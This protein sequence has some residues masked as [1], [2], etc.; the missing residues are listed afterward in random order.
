MGN[1]SGLKIKKLEVSNLLGNKQVSTSARFEGQRYALLIV[2]AC[3]NFYAKRVCSSWNDV[4]LILTKYNLERRERWLIASRKSYASD[5]LNQSV[6]MIGFLSNL[7]LDLS[8]LVIL[9]VY[10]K[11]ITSRNQIPTSLLGSKPISLKIIFQTKFGSVSYNKI[12]SHISM[13]KANLL[14][15]F[16]IFYTE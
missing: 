10:K 5:L 4:A 3:V 11:Q 8:Y 7:I 9:W 14:P 13:S 1:D 6:T 12:C 2:Y 15:A 16:H